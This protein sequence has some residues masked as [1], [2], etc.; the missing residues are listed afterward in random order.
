LTVARRTLVVA[1]GAAFALLVAAL[2]WRAWGERVTLADPAI[3]WVYADFR[4]AVYF[5]ARAF[6]DGRNPYDGAMYAATYPIGNRLTLYSPST[7]LFHAPFAL[8][9]FATGAVLYWTWTLALVLIF[10]RAAWRDAGGDPAATLAFA[11]LVLASRPGQQNLL[12]GQSSMELALAVYVVL[13]HARTSPGLAA[14]AF[15]VVSFKVTWALPLLI[16]MAAAGWYRACVLGIGGALVVNG[17]ALAMLAWH[18]GGIAPLLEPFRGAVGAMNPVAEAHAALSY[19]RVDAVAVLGR[20][21]GTDPGMAVSVAVMGVLLGIAVAAVG[22]ATHAVRSLDDERDLRPLLVLVITTTM[23]TSVYHQPYSVLIVFLPLA[24][25]A[26]GRPTELTAPVR[27]LSFGLLTIPMV[28]FFA[29]KQG[30][31]VLGLADGEGWT[32]LTSVNGLALLAAWAV[33]V[34][35]A[36]RVPAHAAP[37]AG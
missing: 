2:T 35:A 6:L 18:A 23:L 21:L 3:G 11:T 25:L 5:P 7:L 24:F 9:P 4:D 17:A 26:R 33:A 19:T 31:R 29:T 32:V 10:G 22:R 28:N 13:R 16:L 30:L 20:L 15:A 8:V 12:N 27:W 36:F 14:A 34:T 1:G 37:R